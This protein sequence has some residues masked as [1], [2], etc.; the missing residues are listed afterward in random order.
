M[1]RIFLN[2]TFDEF[3]FLLLQVNALYN[4]I[5]FNV[6]VWNLTIISNTNLKLELN[7]SILQY[8]FSFSL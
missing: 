6:E 5:Y 7:Y 4:N 1:S 8:L 2:H 3:V